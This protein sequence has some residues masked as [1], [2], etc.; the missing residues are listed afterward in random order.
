MR[1]R[2]RRSHPGR[3]CLAV[4]PGQVDDRVG[5]LRVREQIEKEIDAFAYSESVD[6]GKPISRASTPEV[7]SLS[8]TAS[9]PVRRKRWR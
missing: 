1:R 3:R 7:Q 2:Q 6:S 4:G 8:I 5:L 9:T